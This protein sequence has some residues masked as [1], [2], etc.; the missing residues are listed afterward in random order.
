MYNYKKVCKFYWIGSILIIAWH[1]FQLRICSLSQ[2]ILSSYPN[3]KPVIGPTHFLTDPFRIGTLQITNL[4]P[5]L[6]IIWNK[7]QQYYW[8]HSL[9]KLY[10]ESFDTLKNMISIILVSNSFRE[11][12]RSNNSNSALSYPVKK[13]M[14][15]K[16]N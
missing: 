14:H 8:S 7:S 9:F 12:F 3:T 13:I 2:S 6:V 1:F 15:N 16:D 11:V 5:A 4:G 10:L